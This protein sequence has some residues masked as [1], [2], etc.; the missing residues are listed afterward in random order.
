[1][2]LT[3]AVA[4]AFGLAYIVLAIYG[5]RACWIAGGIGSALYI[6]VFLEASLPL[7]AVLQVAYVPLAV[8]GWLTWRAGIDARNPPDAWSLRR[9]LYVAACVAGATAL[10]TPVL[11]RYGASAAPFAESLGTWGSVAA[12]WLMARRCA[13]AW[14]WWIVVDAGLAALFLSQGLVQ[15]AALYVGF[16]LLAVA[17]WRSWLKGTATS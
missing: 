6:V 17:G 3:E 5:R 10:S 9:H 15:T 8:Y 16:T 11:A 12:T 4:V 2:A 1:M 13:E 14:L 7:Q